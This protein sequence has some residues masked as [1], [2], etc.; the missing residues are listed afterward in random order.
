MVDRTIICA[1]DRSPIVRMTIA[2]N[3]SMSENPFSLEVRF[4]VLAMVIGLLLDADA[5]VSGNRDDTREIGSWVADRELPVEPGGRESSGATGP[6]RVDGPHG[7][8]GS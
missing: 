3:T 4:V 8:I 1:R 2:I 6:A 5:A 7:A